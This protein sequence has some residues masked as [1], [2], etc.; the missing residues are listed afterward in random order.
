MYNRILIFGDTLGLPQLLRHLPVS[1]VSG[2]VVAEIR[3]HQHEAM[4]ILSSERGIPFFVQPRANRPDYPAF[5]EKIRSLNP[6]LILVNSYSLIISSDILALTNFNAI[7]IHGALL[8]KN[9]GANPTQWVIINEE[10][11]TGVTM[12]YLDAKVDAGDII[13]QR[14]V[15][16]YFT[17]T[18]LDI[19]ARILE[20]T[21]MMLA[22]EIP[23]VLDGTNNRIPQNENQASYRPRR[24]PEDGRIEWAISIRAIHN[25][26]RALVKP[27][28]GAF[29]LGTNG[30]KVVFD[31]YLSIPEVTQLKYSETYGKRSLNNE[32]ITLDPVS[33]DNFPEILRF[34][35]DSVNLVSNQSWDRFQDSI[36]QYGLV[37]SNPLNN[38]VFFC[39]RRNETSEL[40]GIFCLHTID[41]ADKTCYVCIIIDNHIDNIQKHA[42]DALHTLQLFASAELHL[43]YIMVNFEEINHVIESLFVSAGFRHDHIT[44][45]NEKS[46]QRFRMIFN[47]SSGE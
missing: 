42:H 18:W 37:N 23:R 10:P 32:F 33:T 7:N 30:E 1:C 17:D 28:P 22:A 36:S 29:F 27:H 45:N 24:T 34:L 31:H 39:I 6:D 41:Y 19:Q 21:E 25:L 47:L 8:P 38:E 11:E 20:A 14:R 4:K 43:D 2:L 40:I 12:H 44:N 3:P 35:K 15:P 9:R 13:C 5:F 26:I 46:H 16:V